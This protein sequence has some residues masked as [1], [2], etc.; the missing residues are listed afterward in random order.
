M[1]FKVAPPIKCCKCDKAV[2][3]NDKQ[4]SLDGLIYH[5]PCAKCAD[6]GCNIS[7]S[8]FAVVD[9]DNGEKTLLC[10]V[11]YKA[12]FNA[13]GG[14]YAGGSKYAKV[15]SF[16]FPLRLILNFTFTQAY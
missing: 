8:N 6:C 3:A 13:A 16:P 10:K 4:I 9:G 5:G 7:V 12:R 2:Y 14:V 15:R 11:H 1:P